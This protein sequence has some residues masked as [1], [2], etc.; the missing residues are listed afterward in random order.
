MRKSI[1]LLTAFSIFLFSLFLSGCGGGGGTSSGHVY[2]GVGFYS[3]YGYH[4]HDNVDII[5]ERPDRPNR[6]DKPN[7]PGRPDGPTILPISKGPTIQPVRK[8]RPAAAR[9][10]V[11]MGRPR[12]RR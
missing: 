12:R 3:G 6:P 9:R 7:R 10:P 8:S 5:I 11:R 2:H 4:R 1:R